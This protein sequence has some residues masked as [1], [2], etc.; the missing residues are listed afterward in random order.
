MRLRRICSNGSDF[1]AKSKEYSEHLIHCGHDREHVFKIFNEIGLMRRDEA[2][3]SKR[4]KEGKH[5]VFISKF[6]P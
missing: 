3:T 6:N 4:K 1:Y 5:S 2:R